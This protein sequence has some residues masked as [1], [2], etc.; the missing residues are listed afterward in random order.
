MTGRSD[1]S[2]GSEAQPPIGVPLEVKYAGT[3]VRIAIWTGMSWRPHYIAMA[4]VVWR[5]LSS[6]SEPETWSA[7]PASLIAPDHSR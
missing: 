2:D 4:P 1:T 6:G 5:R 7:V 3:G